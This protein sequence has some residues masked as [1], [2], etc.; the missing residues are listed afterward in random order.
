MDYNKEKILENKR[1]KVECD[2]CKSVVYLT[3]LEI[4]KQSTKCINY[5]KE[6]CSKEYYKKYREENKEKRKENAKKYYEKN[7]EKIL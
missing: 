2:N 4:H 5:D 6:K 1:E 3:Q 7:K